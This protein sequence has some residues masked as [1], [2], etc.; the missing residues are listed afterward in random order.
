MI[1]IVFC[2]SKC[3]CLTEDFFGEIVPADITA[4]VCGVVVAV[5]FAFC[6]I[7]K[8]SCQVKGISW[9]SNLIINYGKFI[10]IFADSKH[11]LD[12]IFAVL[13]EYPGNTDD[14]VFF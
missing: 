11:C 4:F 8:E 3:N 5:F 12:K 14:K 2:M 6:H 9:S 1:F 10:V 13:S 7:D